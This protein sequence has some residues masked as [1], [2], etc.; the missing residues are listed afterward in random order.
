MMYADGDYYRQGFAYYDGRK[1]EKL[2]EHR[3]MHSRRWTLAMSIV[4]Y[5]N[6]GG[7]PNDYRKPRPAPGLD[8]NLIA[9]AGAEAGDFSFWQVGSDPTIDPCT[10][11][12][13][14]ANHS[15]A[16]RFGISVGWA[17]ADMYQYQE[18]PGIVPGQPYRAGMW[19][20]HEDG[21]DEHAQLLWCDG[22]FGSE[23]R[24]LTQTESAAG[25][26]W[27][28]YEGPPFT[29]TQSTV[30]IVIRYRHTKA[31]NIASIHVDDIYLRRIGE[32]TTRASGRQ[33]ERSRL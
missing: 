15:G 14:P 8:G 12:P 31:T 25:S 24:L 26:Q 16:H 28:K 2:P 23:E 22:P 29:P 19:A 21:T 27:K 1:V 20:C 4:T 33:T 6:P 9:N 30:T 3:T 13:T 32:A 10:A 5:E 17:E 11:I 18:V 7:A